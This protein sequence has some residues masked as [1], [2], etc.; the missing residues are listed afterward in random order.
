MPKT[1][2]IVED[3]EDT[4]TIYA[5]ALAEKGY[6]VLL[7]TQGAEG[8]HLAR[9]HHPDL[10]LL[11]IRM[12][13]LNGWAAARYL[14]TDPETRNIPIF[15]I[16]AYEVDE[17]ERLLADRVDFDRFLTKPIDPRDVVAAIEA[18]IGPAGPDLEGPGVP[19]PE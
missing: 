2:L 5:S 12:P 3:D 9:R 14:R 1:I 8:V 4:R 11:D 15:A 18:R 19:V 16:S 10:V 6:R 7:A 17:E 13:V